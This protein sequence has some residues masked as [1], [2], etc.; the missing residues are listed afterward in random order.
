M[1]RPMRRILTATGILVFVL[2]AA[3][4]YLYPWSRQQLVR[5]GLSSDAISRMK[6]FY[7]PPQFLP[8]FIHC[9]KVDISP[10]EFLKYVQKLGLRPG[11]NI[12]TLPQTCNVSWWNPPGIDIASSGD[13]IKI[14]QLSVTDMVFQYPGTD[15]EAGEIAVFKNGVLYYVAWN[16]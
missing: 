7:Q 9:V 11:H 4:W 13:I 1:A 16:S 3:A 6:E 8:D 5:S 14:K 15:Q 12:T 2:A 10:A